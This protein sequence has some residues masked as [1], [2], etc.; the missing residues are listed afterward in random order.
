MLGPYPQT[1]DQPEKNALAHLAVSLMTKKNVALPWLLLGRVRR[2][3]LSRWAAF[4]L[5]PIKG[6]FTRSRQNRS[7]FLLSDQFCLA[8]CTIIASIQP[9]DITLHKIR[10]RDRKIPISKLVRAWQNCMDSLAKSVGCDKNRKCHCSCKLG[11]K[12]GPVA[13]WF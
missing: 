7:N 13:R 2:R 9:T 8:I 11:L 4:N 1:L 3:S 5:L 6:S 10:C 12:S